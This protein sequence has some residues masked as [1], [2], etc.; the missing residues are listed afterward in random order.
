[1][2]ILSVYKDRVAFKNS[3]DVLMLKTA[4]AELFVANYISKPLKILNLVFTPLKIY[5][6]LHQVALCARTRLHP[7]L[8]R[9]HTRAKNLPTSS[10]YLAAGLAVSISGCRPGPAVERYLAT[11]WHAPLSLI[12]PISVQ[13]PG[14]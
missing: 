3:R 12:C 10:H 6:T 14:P 9:S 4:Q 8:M 7:N 2:R 5:S 11:C 13:P 1:M